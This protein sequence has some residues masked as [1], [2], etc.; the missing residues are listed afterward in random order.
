MGCLCEDSLLLLFLA[1]WPTPVLPGQGL[2]RRPARAGQ[3]VPPCSRAWA[4]RMPQVLARQL[5]AGTGSA[6]RGPCPKCGRQL[7]Q[8]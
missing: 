7:G 8:H 1:L 6:A 5:L 3:E 4:L 2:Q